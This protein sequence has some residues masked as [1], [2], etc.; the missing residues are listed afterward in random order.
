MPRGRAS[1]ARRI[2]VAEDALAAQWQP[3]ARLSLWVEAPN[4]R[5]TDRQLLG[6][7]LVAAVS[8]LQL[9]GRDLLV[10]KRFSW[11]ITLERGG[12]GYRVGLTVAVD[13]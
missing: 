9:D 4:T 5:K 8:R 3:A 11:P 12:E 13:N 10:T 6:E 1:R 2:I 7:L